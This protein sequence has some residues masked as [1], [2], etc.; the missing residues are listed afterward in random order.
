M[1]KVIFVNQEIDE[2]ILQT[3]LHELM[4]KYVDKKPAKI[5]DEYELIE[6]YIEGYKIGDADAHG[7]IIPDTELLTCKLKSHVA[8]W[9]GYN[10]GYEDKKP[11]KTTHEQGLAEQYIQGYRIGYYEAGDIAG[12]ITMPVVLESA[13]YAWRSGYMDGWKN[14]LQ[15]RRNHRKAKVSK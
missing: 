12:D 10:D 2:D 13:H 9:M 6:E 15:E 8:W 14:G 3:R 11:K 1:K 4:I 5:T 7:K